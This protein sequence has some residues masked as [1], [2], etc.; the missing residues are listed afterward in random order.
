MRRQSFGSIRLGDDIVR[1]LIPLV[2]FRT[3][4]NHPQIGDLKAALERGDARYGCACERWMAILS[5]WRFHI[6]KPILLRVRGEI[7]AGGG[8]GMHTRGVDSGDL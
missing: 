3:D 6:Q 2:C 8:V 1:T 4:A 7:S 5:G